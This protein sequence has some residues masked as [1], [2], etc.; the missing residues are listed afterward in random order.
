MHLRERARRGRR[1]WADETNTTKLRSLRRYYRCSTARTWMVIKFYCI[2]LD[3]SLSLSHSQYARISISR[4]AEC[5]MQSAQNN[6]LSYGPPP[7]RVFYYVVLFFSSVGCCAAAHWRSAGGPAANSSPMPK[8]HSRT[9]A[10]S[11]MSARAVRVSQWEERIQCAIRICLPSV[12]I[13]FLR[14]EWITM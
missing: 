4:A 5:E 7:P 3:L 14:R 11:L 8:P 10:Q 1:L 6:Q 13:L 9:R 12:E 2:R